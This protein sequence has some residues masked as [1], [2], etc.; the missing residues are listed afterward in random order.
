M[1]YLSLIT[2]A[3]TSLYF[4]RRRSLCH[5]CSVVAKVNQPTFQSNISVE[6]NQLMATIS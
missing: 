5:C 4:H 1:Q 2:H 3:D 6:D